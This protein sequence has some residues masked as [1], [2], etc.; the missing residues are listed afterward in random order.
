RS[1]SDR[2]LH[3]FR[4]AA[5][6]QEHESGT[7]L[8]LS[9][10][11]ICGFISPRRGAACWPQNFICA[12]PPHRS[13]APAAPL[14]QPARSPTGCGAANH[15]HFTAATVEPALNI[16]PARPA[17]ASA[18]AFI[19]GAKRAIF[20]PAQSWRNRAGVQFSSNNFFRGRIFLHRRPGGR[21][22]MQNRRWTAF[23]RHAKVPIQSSRFPRGVNMTQPAGTRKPSIQ[24]DPRRHEWAVILAGGDGTRLKS[25]TR[26]IAGDERPKQFCRVLGGAT[27]LEETRSRALLEFAGERLVYVVNRAHRGYYR[28]ILTSAGDDRL[29][30]Q[31]RNRGTAPAILYSL[32]RIAAADPDAVVAF[33]P[34]DHYISESRKFM[35]QVRSA[36]EHARRRRDLAILLGVEPESPEVEYGWIEPAAPIDGEGRI[37]GVRRFWEK[38]HRLLAQALQLRGCLWNSFVMVASARALLDT[39]ATTISNLHG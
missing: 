16:F 6:R 5:L 18:G 8:R 25:L 24:P 11:P 14:K 20:T 9:A 7:K 21:H 17:R 4:G 33:F 35:A 38:P 34:S 12:L 32:L 10:G 26:K 36:L 28:P 19:S 30:A 1:G 22:P 37:L 3:C 27:L 13:P 23:K 29:I 2:G 31:P 15:T 39:L